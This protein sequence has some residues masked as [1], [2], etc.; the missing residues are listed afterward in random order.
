MGSSAHFTSLNNR[1]R[2]KPQ[3]GQQGGFRIDPQYN[4]KLVGSVETTGLPLFANL[5]KF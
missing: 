4:G 3:A 5:A 2:L 1:Y